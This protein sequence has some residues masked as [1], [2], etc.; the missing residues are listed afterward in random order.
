M[1][2]NVEKIINVE[3]DVDESTVSTG[4]CTSGV[5]KYV[6]LYVSRIFQRPA[7]EF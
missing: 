1:S 7:Y 5:Q 2:K 4:M 3:I 6:G